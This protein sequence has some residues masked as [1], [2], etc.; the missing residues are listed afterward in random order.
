MKGLAKEAGKIIL[1]NFSLDT[2]GEWKDDGSILTKTDKIINNLVRDAVRKKYPNY[3]YI[4]EEGSDFKGNSRL[5]WI[6]DPVD[7][8]TPFVLGV[9]TCVFS[10]ALLDNGTPIMGI[11]HDP[12]LKRTLFAEKNKGCFLNDKKVSV[13]STKGGEKLKYGYVSYQYADIKSQFMSVDDFVRQ[14]YIGVN[15]VST[16]YMGMLVAM[17]EL[18]AV[19][20]TG[21][22]PWDHAVLKLAIE[23]AGGKASDLSGNEQLYNIETNGFLGS[24]GQVHSKLREMVKKSMTT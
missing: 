17:G 15:L 7:G 1:D 23:E 2:K 12:F 21:K 18:D 11:I 3:E 16:I 14:G 5:V 19:I 6:C 4:G 9:P 8:T 24:N 10:L 13:S 20:S 22:N